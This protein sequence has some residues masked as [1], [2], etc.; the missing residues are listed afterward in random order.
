MLQPLIFQQDQ[1]YE[2]D[3]LLR[4]LS[5]DG[6]ERMD[7]VER[8]GHFSVRGDIIDVFAVNYEQPMR[9]EFFG[10]TLEKLRFLMRQA[11][12][13]LTRRRPCASCPLPR[14]S[15]ETKNIRFWIT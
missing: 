10:D 8:R 3:T 9:L 6:Y 15:P 1:D 13:L 5:E 4:Q 14:T 12:N 7:L 11:R 2:R